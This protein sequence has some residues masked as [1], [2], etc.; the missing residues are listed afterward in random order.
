MAVP[1]PRLEAR[2]PVRAIRAA[3]WL[4]YLIGFG[5]LLSIGPSLT[6][7][8]YTGSSF[9]SLYGAPPS[10]G[11]FLGSNP[12]GLL[13]GFA[14]AVVFGIAFL[15]AAGVEVLAGYW[16]GKSLKKGGKLGAILCL[17]I[18]GFGIGFVLPGW[19]LFPSVIMFLLAMGWKTLL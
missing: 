2:R 15:V 1:H 13:L 14:G 19:V 10:F 5:T 17:C 18:A 7:N 9:G 16:L 6:Y 3:S 11:D 8:L 12:I 4:S